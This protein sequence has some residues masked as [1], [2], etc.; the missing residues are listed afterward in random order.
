MTKK[1]SDAVIQTMSSST[2]GTDPHPVSEHETKFVLR[3]GAAEMMIRWLECRCRPDP[4]F[5]AGI[6]SSI[7][8]DTR[9][10][11]FLRE[12]IN[13]DFLKTKVRVRWYAD[14]D[15][16]EPGDASF[17]EAKYKVGARREKVRIKTDYTWKWLSR[18]ALDNGKLHDI[19]QMLWSKGLFFPGRLYP[20][21]LIRYKRRRFVAPVTQARLSID[22]DISAPEVN[23][24]MLP[25]TNPFRLEEAVFELKGKMV[26]LPSFLHQITALGCRKNSFSKYMACYKRIMRIWF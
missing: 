15:T 3:N 12:K 5:P 2:V 16:E 22:Y 7:Y 13:S 24:Q 21:F 1:D 6:I 14:I 23:L 20:A 4:E 19:P 11:R 9:D 18:V 17:L 8:Y 25:R 26:E 10:W